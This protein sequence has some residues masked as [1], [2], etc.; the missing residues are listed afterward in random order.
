MSRIGAGFSG[1]ERVVVS[2]LGLKTEIASRF[3]LAINALQDRFRCVLGEVYDVS[4]ASSFLL[5]DGTYDL[6]MW[7]RVVYAGGAASD[8]K[9]DRRSISNDLGSVNMVLTDLPYGDPQDVGGNEHGYFSSFGSDEID[10]LRGLDIVSTNPWS[11]IFGEHKV[12][13][14]LLMMFSS[15]ILGRVDATMEVEYHDQTRGCLFDYC[16]DTG[17]MMRL[18]EL[19][20]E[21]RAPL[22]AQCWRSIDVGLRRGTYRV[23]EVASAMRVFWRSMGIRSAFIAVPYSSAQENGAIESALNEAHVKTFRSDR[24]NFIKDIEI[25]MRV[26]IKCVDTIVAD[27]STDNPNV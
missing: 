1:V 11:A 8:H 24:F 27:V 23:D 18:I 14:Y 3:C 10:G 4:S 6:D 5:G 25:R 16:M 9:D 15:W 2:C 7:A 12:V 21:I 19:R 20:E 17:D 22:C 26:L 13:E